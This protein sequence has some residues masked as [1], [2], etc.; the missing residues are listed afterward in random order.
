VNSPICID[1]SILIRLL[2]G[3]DGSERVAVLWSEWKANRQQLI[4]PSLMPYE[5]ANVLH[6][7]VRHG[8]LQP[9][10]AAD[11][12][13]IA[14][15][16]NIQLYRDAALHTQAANLARALDLPA[17]YDAHYLALAQQM[18]AVFW[19]ADQKLVRKTEHSLDFV[20]GI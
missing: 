8:S 14:L 1:A 19:T 6:Q 3:G 13:R 2:I 18:N 10:K 20:R 11:A 9:D 4:A 17:T 12:L 16:L 7:Y 15:S 5:A